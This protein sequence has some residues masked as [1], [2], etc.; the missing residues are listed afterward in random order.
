M[1][2]CHARFWLNASH[3][4]ARS[5]SRAFSASDTLCK[6]LVQLKF[7]SEINEALSN[8]KTTHSNIF[9]VTVQDNGSIPSLFLD[10]RLPRLPPFNQNTKAFNTS[11]SIEYDFSIL[12]HFL[13]IM[14]SIADCLPIKPQPRCPYISSYN[15]ANYSNYTLG[16]IVSVFLTITETVGIALMKVFMN[17][18]KVHQ[19]R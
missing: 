10:Y 12:W 3:N 7:L 8:Q 9:L 16:F 6:Q 4:A 14:R 13:K 17:T 15:Y 5:D 2:I 11:E 19:V 18:T 1:A